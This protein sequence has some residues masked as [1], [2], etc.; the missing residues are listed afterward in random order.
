[1]KGYSRNRP[2]ATLRI[3]GDTDDDVYVV[4]IDERVEITLSCAE[5]VRDLLAVLREPSTPC[6]IFGRDGNWLVYEL[7][8]VRLDEDERRHLIQRLESILS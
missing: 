6:D 3:E 5:R 1:M 8:C 4:Y 2:A 7:V